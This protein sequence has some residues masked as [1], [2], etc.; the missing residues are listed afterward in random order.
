VNL[1]TTLKDM[2][3]KLKMFRQLMAAFF[4]LAAI[5]GLSSCEKYSWI[6]EKVNPV[7]TVHFST[8]IQP[9]FTSNCA[10]CHNQNN[11]PDLRS[12]FS[13]ASLTTGGYVDLPGENSKLYKQMINSSHSSRSTDVDK[14]HVLIWI[15]QGAH[16]N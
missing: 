4:V 13:W 12:G 7:D 2:N 8:V 9:I 6:P 16:N 1:L 15:N 3:K 14:Q 10:S 5:V 11:L